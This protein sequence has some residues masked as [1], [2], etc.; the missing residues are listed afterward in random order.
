MSQK[1]RNRRK[2]SLSV[3]IQLL[4]VIVG[5]K[6]CKLCTVQV[7]IAGS[8]IFP[9]GCCQLWTAFGNSTEEGLS[10]VSGRILSF[11]D[12]KEILDDQKAIYILLFLQNLTASKNA[13]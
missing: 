9:A 10:S 2:E 13:E 7:P 4:A 12:F 11:H 6:K 3:L 5:K 1:P 8:L